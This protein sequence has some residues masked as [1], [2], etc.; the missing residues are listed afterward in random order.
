MNKLDSFFTWVASVPKDK[1][2]HGLVGALIALLVMRL[3]SL[4]SVTDGTVRL[5]ALI[6]VFSVGLAKELYDRFAHRN[7]DWLDWLATIV[8]GL[9]V[10]ILVI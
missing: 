2:L 4:F 3:L 10:V 5:C 9:V 8:G 6:V 7:F 1:L